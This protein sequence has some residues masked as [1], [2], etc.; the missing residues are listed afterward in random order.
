MAYGH[1]GDAE[2]SGQRREGGQLQTRR[3]RPREYGGTQLVVDALHLRTPALHAM[4]P[5]SAGY[6]RATDILSNPG[7]APNPST[8]AA[9]EHEQTECMIGQARTPSTSERGGNHR[10]RPW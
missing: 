4:T 3:E 9:N 7:D 1:R 5:R 2:P 6:T 8:E 10:T